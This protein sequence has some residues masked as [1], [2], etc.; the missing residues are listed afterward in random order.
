MGLKT[1]GFKVILFCIGVFLVSFPAGTCSQSLSLTTNLTSEERITEIDNL[2]RSNPEGTVSLFKDI[3]END[4]DSRVKKRAILALG[5]VTRQDRAIDVRSFLKQITS[6]EEGALLQSEALATLHLLYNKFPEEKKGA[7]EI[8]LLGDLIK[9]STVTLIV[10]ISS[11]INVEMVSAG[12]IKLPY[13]LRLLSGPR[14]WT[15]SLQE[16]EERVLEYQVSLEETGNYIIPFYLKL[17]FGNRV[18]YE[19]TKKRIVLEVNETMGRIITPSD[20]EYPQKV[21]RTVTIKRQK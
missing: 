14:K 20:P 11:K 15:G 10:T 12:L 13:G 4:T 6:G 16:N 8:E 7:L 21:K 19:L 3:I 9:G 5:Q 17:D 1:F 18:D 2:Q